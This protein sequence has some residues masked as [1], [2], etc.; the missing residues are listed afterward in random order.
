MAA[1]RRMLARDEGVIVQ[2]GSAL[3]F[4]S[5][6][7]Q[8]AYC[9]AKH[10]LVGFTE[11]LRCE[12]LHEH[13]R[14][15]VTMVRRCRPSIPRNS[16]GFAIAWRTAPS[17]FLRSTNRRWPRMP[18]STPRCIPT[19]GRHWLGSQRSWRWKATRSPPGRWTAIWA[20]PATKASSRRS[21]AIGIKQIISSRP[22]PATTACA[23]ASMTV[24]TRAATS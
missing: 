2:V 4:R 21:T 22:C 11:S 13:R 10:A 24:P 18:W 17:P 15:R 20:G 6:P 19:R 8:A 12:L 23:D 16:I 5:I 7:L 14:V 3:A 1:L 9:G